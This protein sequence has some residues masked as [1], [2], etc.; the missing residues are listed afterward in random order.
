MIFDNPLPHDILSHNRQN[1]GDGMGIERSR[2]I[3]SG[4]SRPGDEWQN[5]ELTGRSK[6]P[7]RF[8]GV[9]FSQITEASPGGKSPWV[10]SLDGD[11]KF[12]WYP[13]PS[14]VDDHVHNTDFDDTSWSSMPVPANWEMHGYGT[15]QYSNI[16]YPFSHDT[17]HPP[18]IDPNDNPT[19]V[20][21]RFFTIPEDWTPRIRD[22]VLRFEGIRSA[23]AVWLN[24][25]E[26]GY[27]Q[28]TYSP[29]EFQIG[30]FL[31]AGKNQLTVKVYKWCAGSYLED[32]DMWRMGGIIRSVS[33]I[34]PPHGG[35]F[36]VFAAC[37]FDAIF[38]D[39]EMNVSVELEMPEEVGLTG[40]T[41]SWYLYSPDGE[42]IYASYGPAAVTYQGS[43]GVRIETSVPV[44]E[45]VQWSAEN[46]YLYKLV[47]LLSEGDGFV[48][49]VRVL[50][51]GFR[52]VDI[53][54]GRSGGVL[55]LNGKPI[56]LRGVNR[57]DIHPRY[58]QAVPRH[59][60]ESDLILMK[61]HNINAVRCSHYPNPEALYEIADRLGL[62][63]IDEANVESHGLRHRLPTSRPEW[64]ANC[65][66]RMERMVLIHRNHPCIIMWSLGNEAGHGANF[67]KM[68]AAALRLDQSRPIH[69]EGDHVLDTSDV[70]SL[71]YADV[72]VVER[73]GKG[74]RV[75]VAVG[76]Q[77]RPLGWSVG[78]RRYRHKPFILCEF[79]HAMGNSLGN[80]SDYME[81]I[82]KYPNIAGG[83]IWDFADQALYKV[84]EQGVE[85]L[86][87]G[88]EFGEF[89]HDG[90][91][92][93]NGIVTADRK[94]QP[95]LAEVKALYAPISVEMVNPLEGIV[96]IHNRQSFADLK[97]FEITWTLHRDGVD[98][99]EG[100][101][102]QPDI[103][104]G[105]ERTVHLYRDLSA[106]P[107]R[108]EGYLDFSVTLKDDCPWAEAGYELARLQ[109][110]VPELESSGPMKDS[111][112]HHL[113]LSDQQ[114][115][116]SLSQQIDANRVD[117]VVETPEWR[118]EELKDH[119][120]IAGAGIGAR[121]RLSNGALDA[122][123]FGM[124]NVL[125]EALEPDFF[126]APTDNEQ[127]GY[128]GFISHFSEK[129][130]RIARK[131]AHR[132][133][134]HRWESASRERCLSRWKVQYL[135]QGPKI[136]LFLKVPGFLGRLKEIL[137]FRADG[138]LHVRLSGIPIKEMVRFGTR[139]ALDGRYRR[140]QWYGKGPQE[141]Y[142]DRQSGACV[143]RYELDADDLAFDYLNPQESGN[144][145]GIRRVSF[146]DGGSAVA[147]RFE[148]SRHINF[149]ARF[150]SR[151]AVAA[152]DHPHEIVKSQHLHVH[153][154]GRQR[155]VGGSIPGVLNLMSKY[156]MKGFRRYKLSFRINRETPG[157]PKQHISSDGN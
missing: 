16:V 45:P 119:L 52:Q 109:L 38:K 70:F 91:F 143:G 58:G 95:E 18:A 89:P 54:S 35:I 63:V 27:T 9:P 130:Y 51:W 85:Y 87:Y 14:E 57:H 59:V 20:Y 112:F 92:C 69:Y 134:G 94:P 46:P 4:A 122:L 111:I 132:R 10:M 150:A 67:R 149:S 127:D 100:I 56:K 113:D 136:T 74:R 64:T 42:D 97:A 5:P 36:D 107:I 133:Y 25:E 147:F 128:A 49:D 65:V 154:D 108:G 30:R 121:I 8:T 145:T 98:V 157:A 34:A 3:F 13:S 55:R 40:R 142:V 11:W 72:G 103:P 139:M 106:F 77:G 6:L 53:T 156:R 31:K 41:L 76:E 68:K 155:G 138:G 75:R 43:D 84:N 79:A 83:F 118:C 120:V 135:P 115:D 37:R 96:R 125:K 33:V 48:V 99:A 2:F 141:C 73:I 86:A 24:G 78:R 137:E 60:I 104:A 131:L 29:A 152:A 148:E 32:Q 7:G 61:Q 151:E 1:G 140:V 44:S 117:D 50:D 123:D 93:A 19:G 21:R 28:D 39:A 101:L 71:M 116:D 15:P 23:A 146:S 110:T 124:G 144:R 47:V 22:M 105:A 26:I 129:L 114:S 82:E 90:I 66:E 88:G 81:L 12:A 62:Y 17:A 80:F 102:R 126:R 153:L